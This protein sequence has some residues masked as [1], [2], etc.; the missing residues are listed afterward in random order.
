MQKMRNTGFTLV[1]LMI[2]VV[3]L[4]IFASIALPGFNALIE[5]NRAK[6]IA[7]EFQALLVAARTDAVTKRTSVSVSH[8]D[9]IWS[10]D[11]RK[12]TIP[13]SIVMSADKNTVTFNANG[14]ATESTTTFSDSNTIYTI[15][16]KPAGLIKR[17]QAQNETIE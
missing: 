12:V 5:S 14:T 13:D 4:G 17:T 2:V 11:E 10:T 3:I 9:G 16:T 7:D 15:T 6:S 1:E 8:T